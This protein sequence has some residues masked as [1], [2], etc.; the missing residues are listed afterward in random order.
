MV[1][2]REMQRKR[3][4]RHKKKLIC[5]ICNKEFK[6]IRGRKTCS[7]ECRYKLVSIS[8]KAS[9]KVK[10]FHKDPKW[11]EKQR[12]DKIGKPSPKIG[13]HLTI[14]SKEKL[15]KIMN[16]LYLENPEEKFERTKKAN[17]A[18]RQNSAFYIGRHE[19]AIK[20]E[21]KLFENKG[22][23]CLALDRIRPDFIAMKKDKIYAVEVEFGYIKPE[24][25]EGITFFN[26]VVWINKRRVKQ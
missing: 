10:N 17:E 9:E 24:K 26:D 20:K 5:V 18:I 22:Y 6:H 12:L 21:I 8:E 11:I 15:S 13:K 4:Y 2:E 16:D 3:I 25:Y 14:K 19:K 7:K 1:E 23:K